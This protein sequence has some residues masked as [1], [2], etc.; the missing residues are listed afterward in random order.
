MPLIGVQV[1]ERRQRLATGVNTRVGV[2]VSGS[3]SGDLITVISQI[4]PLIPNTPSTARGDERTGENA[5]SRN[6]I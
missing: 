3:R 6:V 5:L 4:I 1:E 2:D